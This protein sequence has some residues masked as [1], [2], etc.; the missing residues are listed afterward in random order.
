MNTSPQVL[1]VGSGAMACLF[2]ARLAAA[3]AAVTMLGS[4]AEGLDALSRAGVSI[5]EADGLR[6]YPVRV[7]NQPVDCAGIPQALVLVKSWQ[8]ER[9]ALQLA[10]CLPADGLALTLQ[11]GLGNAETLSSLLGMGRVAVGATTAG[12][13]LEGP[14][15]VRPTGS[16]E[17]MLPCL[18]IP[19]PL[20]ALFQRS[21]FT[22]HDVPDIRVIQWG[23]LVINVAINPL[24]ALLR[25]TNGELLHRPSAR[26]LM[27]DLAREAA[28]VAQALGIELSYTDP[29]ATVEAVAQRTAANRSSMLQDVSRSAPTEIDA[30][31][32]A[33]VRQASQIGLDVPVNRALWLLVKCLAEP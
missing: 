3:Q 30:I 7:T 20:I 5:R 12:A 24:T 1:I 27:A 29:L 14:G 11:N 9:A 26:A 22:V 25:I 4:W 16:G 2:A 17:I 21:G 31:C 19:S 13:Y 28:G 8:T 23:K 32:G 33:V 18:N 15:I 10:Q 6:T